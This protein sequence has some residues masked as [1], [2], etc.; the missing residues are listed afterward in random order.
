V[1]APWIA[2]AAPCIEAAL[3]PNIDSLVYPFAAEAASLN[4]M[5]KLIASL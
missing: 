1:A 3:K 2:D 4:W 5:T